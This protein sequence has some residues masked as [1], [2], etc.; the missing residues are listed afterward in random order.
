MKSVN[1]EV[2]FPLP[3]A[4]LEM[5]P[6]FFVVNCTPVTSLCN[7][8]RIKVGFE[9]FY[10]PMV[11]CLNFLTSTEHK[12]CGGP[13]AVSGPVSRRVQLGTALPAAGSQRLEP[14]SMVPSLLS[15]GTRFVFITHSC[16][17]E[18]P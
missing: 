8:H 10:N 18:E 13:K 6:L 14:K 1:L 16:L 3:Q 12:I 9:H 17:Q 11:D 2:T 7:D 4:V 5:G 15:Q